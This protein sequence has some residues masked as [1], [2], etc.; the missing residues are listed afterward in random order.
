[1]AKRDDKEYYN[2]YLAQYMLKRYHERRAEAMRLLGGKCVMCG[3][4]EKLEFDHIDASQKNFEVSK[5]WAISYERFLEEIKKCQLLCK[6]HH[7]HKSRKEAE[8]RRP[9]RHGTFY[10]IRN[11]KCKCSV[12]REFK[13]AYYVIRNQQRR[14]NRQS[15]STAR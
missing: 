6:E 2:A 10:A 3:T 11:K 1:M 5:L 13:Q 8:A 9:W 7:I 14:K 4:I 12:C 15:Q